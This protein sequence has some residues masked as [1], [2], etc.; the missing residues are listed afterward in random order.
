MRLSQFVVAGLLAGAA[1]SLSAQV[2]PLD[3]AAKLFGV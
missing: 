1:T 3:Q 2:M